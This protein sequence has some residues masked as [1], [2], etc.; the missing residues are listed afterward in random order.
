MFYSNFCKSVRKEIEAPLGRRK[1]NEEIK[2][3][4]W[5]LIS[6]K[7]LRRFPSNLVCGVAY[8]ADTSVV[9]L[10]PIG[11]EI[12]ELQRCENHVFFLPVNILTV[13]RAGF[14]GRTTHYCLS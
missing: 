6:Q 10:V 14:L 13:W 9:K 2:T 4:L 8:L 11:Y 1:K 5:P 12:M 3:K 7:R